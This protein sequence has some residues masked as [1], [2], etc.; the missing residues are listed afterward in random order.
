MISFSVLEQRIVGL[1][2]E[3]KGIQCLWYLRTVERL[4]LL[5]GIDIKDLR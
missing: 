4:I 3:K 5:Q 2:I 1:V